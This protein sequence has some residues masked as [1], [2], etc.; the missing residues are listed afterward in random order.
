MNSGV[1]L[2]ER[3]PGQVATVR[4]GRWSR[5]VQ[6]G[7]GCGRVLVARNPPAARLRGGMGWLL[8][9]VAGGVTLSGYLW[10]AVLPWLRV[11][12]LKKRHEASLALGPF[13]SLKTPAYVG[14]VVPPDQKCT[15]P[16]TIQR[17]EIWQPLLSRATFMVQE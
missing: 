15:I 7:R 10:Q 1:F 11:N 13:G 4:G 9:E 17:W 12:C 16:S 3:L 14:S 2:L 6:L 5:D 8:A